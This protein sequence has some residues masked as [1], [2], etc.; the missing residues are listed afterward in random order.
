[1]E[2]ELLPE[3]AKEFLERFVYGYDG[4]IKGFKYEAIFE[5]QGRRYYNP[6]LEIVLLI[7]DTEVDSGWS[8]VTLFMEGFV[9]LK[10]YHTDMKM[11]I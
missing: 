3:N 5:R 2:T 8:R 11:G 4:T 9:G 6:I 1:M 10:I 7:Q